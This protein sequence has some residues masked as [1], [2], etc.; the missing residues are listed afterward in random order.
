MFGRKRRRRARPAANAASGDL[1]RVKERFTRPVEAY[2]EAHAP[3]L[4][5][6]HTGSAWSLFYIRGIRARADRGHWKAF[7]SDLFATP[8]RYSTLTSPLVLNY[9]CYS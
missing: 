8:P 2:D 7:E 6:G 5:C 9:L 3:P 1:L 4:C